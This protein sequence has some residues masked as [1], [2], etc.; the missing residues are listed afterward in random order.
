[1]FEFLTAVRFGAV[2][3]FLGKR[4]GDIRVEVRV[5]IHP[6]PP[7]A[8]RLTPIEACSGRLLGTAGDAEGESPEDSGSMP[9]IEDVEF[10]DGEP[11]AD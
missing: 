7:S 4:Q 10:G 2:T 1:M 9:V 11:G 8:A 3:A 5:P 6:P